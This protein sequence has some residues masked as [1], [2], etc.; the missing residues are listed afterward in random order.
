MIGANHKAAVVRTVE[1]KSVYAV[2]AK[3][4]R[5]MFDLARSAISDKFHP[6]D[7]R[8]RTMAVDNGKEFAAHAHI[9]Q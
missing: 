3:V 9:D 4:E 7:A 6:L 8:F 2:M 5:K 1:S